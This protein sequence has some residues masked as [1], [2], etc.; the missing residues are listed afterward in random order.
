MSRHKEIDLTKVEALPIGARKNKVTVKDFA[1][2]SGGS[3]FEAFWRSLPGILAGAEIKQLVRAMEAAKE[4]GK[5]V[6]WLMGAHVIKVGLSPM[7]ID[8]MERGYVS[9]VGLN[10][11]GA[12]HDS[13]VAM[14]GATSED[15]AAGIRSGEF[16][17]SKETAEL[18]NGAVNVGVA[19]GLGLGE[20]A[21]RALA[22]KGGRGKSKL[23]YPGLSILGSAF[24]LGIP[25]TVH[26]AIGTDIVHL[27]PSFDASLAGEG[28]YRDFKIMANV[29]SRV[30][31]GGVI[32]NV[33]SSVIL[34]L[35][36]EKS[37][38]AARNL[39]CKVEKFTGANLD[40]IKHYRPNLNP[41]M[42][43]VELGGQ[44]ITIIGHHEL[45]VPLIYWALRTGVERKSARGGGAK[46][47]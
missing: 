41:V 34:P 20:A 12:I 31:G 44:G 35:V 8:L 19:E 7:V 25:A 45:T 22:A 2:L 21:G 32:L 5:P 15:V 18:L 38:A 33:G 1:G 10:G 37:L 39:G 11:A 13:E 4:K 47:K 16:G 23:K 17:M 46:G 27:H 6:I 30:G 42:R 24:R 26:I 3:G 43:A 9:A 36:V 40:F 14:I 29:I 28:T